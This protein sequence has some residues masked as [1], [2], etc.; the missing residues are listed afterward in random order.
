MNRSVKRILFI[1]DYKSGGGA[2]VVLGQL[3]KGL[4]TKGFEAELFY[5]TERNEPKKGNPFSYIYSFYYKQKLKK[6]LAEFKPNIV[7]LLNYYHI[8]TPSVL[9]AVA[10]YKR[11]LPELMVI[12]TAH[13]FHLLAPNSGLTSFSF[14]GN[15]IIRETPVHHGSGLK[16]WSLL[17]KKWD[18]RGLIFSLLKTFQWGLAYM[19]KRADRVIDSIVTPGSFM[20]SIMEKEFPGK[21]VVL[22]RNPYIPSGFG[23]WDLDSMDNNRS[24]QNSPKNS[25]KLVFAGRIAQEKGLIPFVKGISKENWEKIE[26]HIFGTGPQLTEL[27]SVIA[28]IDAGN[29]CFLY[30]SRS[31]SEILTTLGNFDALLLPSLL[32]ENAPL[33]IVEAS[34]SGLRIFA[35]AWGGIKTLAEFCGG[36]Y[37]FNPE[38]P[39]SFNPVLERIVMD[40]T[41][42]TEIERDMGKIYSAFAFSAFIDKHIGLYSFPED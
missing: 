40:I 19:V 3:I 16:R 10:A 17:F 23:H 4:K 41:K 1:N 24:A 30:G 37:L 2:E 14:T 22:I 42:G 11:R 39:G 35:S 7:H 20:F 8:L 5:G 32:F 9:D 29:Q 31:H 26:I 36:E 38:D 33:S 6:V 12:Y 34:F 21:N 28:E 25:V 15:R 18:H 13:D 27:R